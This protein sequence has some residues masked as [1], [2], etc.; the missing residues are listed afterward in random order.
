MMA[1]SRQAA[2]ETGAAGS[3]SRED[4]GMSWS[5]Q[6]WSPEQP[7]LVA[8][9]TGNGRADIVGFGLDGVWSSLNNGNG[10]FQPP[11][12]VLSA[13]SFHTG[14]MVERHLRMLADLSGD[15]RADIAGFGDA[16]VWTA[17]NNGDGTFQPVKFVVANLGYN[18]G[19]RVDQHP[20]FLADVT[21][22]GKA[23]I[24]GF[25]NDGVW[26]ALSNGDG[27][28]QAPKFVLNNMGYNQGWRVDQHPRFVADVT[29][30]G[31]ADIIGFGN[32]GV[33]VALSNGDGTFQ[34]AKLV[35]AG[36]NPNQG[37]QGARHPRMMGDLSGDRRA[38]IVG[39][40]DAGVYSALSNGN[41]S[42][43][44]ATF[45]L[46]EMGYNKGWRVENHPRFAADV[47]GD[48]K[49]D[50]VGFGNDGVWV[51]VTGG[52]GA[53]LVLAGF[54]YNQ[55]WRVASHPRYL[56]DLTG[57]RKA[58][59]IG[60]GNDGVWIALSNG[61]GSFQPASFVLA[62]FGYHAGPVVQKI[63]IDFQTHNDDL[64]SNSLLHIF[65]KNRSS[66]SSDSGG[67]GTYAA[68][69]QAYLEH[70]ADW[71]GKN[72]YLGYA[73]NA[74][75]GQALG[76]N[77]TKQINIQLRSKPIPLEE[78]L[79]PAVNIHILAKSTD[80]WKFDYTLTITL[81]DGTQLPPFSSNIN[82]LT[83]IVLNQDNRDYSGI[84]AE[85]RPIPP[86]IKPGTNSSLTGVAIEFNTHGDD[87]NSD[88]TLNIHIVNRLSAT[89]SQDISVATDV[90]KGQTFPDSGDTYK[91]IDLPFAANSIL[92]RDMV[93]PVV[94]INIAAGEDQWIFDYRVTFFFGPSQPYSWT[95]SGV[96]LDQEHHKHMG[97]Y[98]GRPFPTLFYPQAPITPN[99]FQRNKSISLPFVRQK[100]QELFNSRQFLGSL[101]PF[102]KFKI[103]STKTF[104]DQI[105][106]TFTDLQSIQNDPP[107]P[108]GQP[109]DPN[110]RMG[111]RYSHSIS[112]LGPL[113][114]WFGIG[115]HLND[116]NSQSITLSVNEGDNQTPLTVD[117]QFETDGPTEITGS[118]TIDVIKFQITLH[119]TLRFHEA[120]HAVDLMGWVDD[121]TTVTFTPQ[122]PTVSNLPP[123]Y[124][125]AGT[126]LGKT[127]NDRT[128]DPARYRTDLIGQ[129]VHVVFTTSSAFDPGGIIQKTMREGIFNKFSDKDSITK[130]TLRDSIN[131]LA[132]S[133]LMGGVIASGNP[134]LVPYPGP[135]HLTAVTPPNNGVVTLSYLSPQNSFVYQKPADW[136]TSLAPGA[137]A[138]IDHIVVLMQEN[139]SFDHML[140]YLS[141]P[142]EK[143]GMNRNDVD[144]LKGG[145]FNMFNGRKCGSFRLAAGDTIFSPGPPNGAERVAAAIN[146]GKMDGFVQAQA[147]E[148]GPATAHRVMGHHTA[149]NVP[150]Y[151]SLARDFAI[152]QRWFASH[153]GPTFPNRFYSLTGRPNVDAWGAWEYA[154]SS[155][156]RP[157]LTDTIF[158]HLS[159]RGVSWKCFEH[160]YSFLRFFERHTFDGDNI[161]SFTDPLK[162]FAALARSGNLPS[163]SFIEPHYVDYPPDSFCDEPPSDIRN[164]QKFMR[165]LVETLVASPKWDKTLLIITYDEH[166]GFYDHVPPPVAVPVA[167]GMLTTTGLRVPFFAVSP[168]VKSG[169]VF[170]TDTLH[171]DHTSILKT[172][173]RRFMSNNPPYMGARYAAAHDLSEILE[174]QIRPGPF[175]PFIPYTLVYAAS[176]MCLDLPGGSLSAGASLWQF[177]PNGTD[178]Q[179][180][181]LEDAGNGFFYIRTFAGLYVT[182]NS[183]A[184]AA[185]GIKQDRKYAPGSTG[186]LN[187]DLQK[188]KFSFSGFT[189]IE[190]AN[191]TITCAGVPG[192]VLQP[193]NGSTGSGV[194]VVLGDPAPTH[195]PL[196]TANPWTVTSSFLP[197][198]KL[199]HA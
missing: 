191:Y 59:I 86:R 150:T 147:D 177:S 156:L 173:T 24:I 72:P 45:I 13:F 61:D 62:D 109:L 29:G 131:A 117:L 97:V 196:V 93:L 37:W 34:Q 187:P 73:I 46:A 81:D 22:D 164:S 198:P 119:F 5:G 28:F 111:I 140:G 158:D 143:G 160:F 11:N 106:P 90:A 31:K 64:N 141:L 170:G 116:I 7:R 138:N 66:D 113:T 60:F 67:P 169:S 36:F 21:G 181:R 99:Q 78:L 182:A 52:S 104:G 40:G 6:S 193:V 132:S 74:G 12:M 133:W 134:E 20:R 197:P 179:K 124:K 2:T 102:L 42:F 137:L 129:V 172:I 175:R 184:G 162:G 127:L 95:V 149:D 94:F 171:F 195:S 168:W 121:M 33:W 9:L 55:G 85:F 77:S 122:S 100:L 16:G 65:V 145:E 15:G 88:T 1:T 130:V 167:P 128:L 27:T 80:T 165:S 148:C 84:C 57:D 71:F 19:W 178:A 108:D 82:G 41:G 152:C 91:R 110:F 49:A 166:G 63:T 126:F 79:L 39:F 43:A 54:C 103:D 135:C 101:D 194:A 188:W 4:K 163:V 69:L 142:F 25:G 125:V 161:G 186:P 120:T 185:P 159:E 68:N 18:Q 153:P 199:T 51:S 75:Q 89:S 176:K 96:V 115:V 8:D 180:F 146:G 98:N 183:T 58:D 151:D 192:K 136:P 3:D 112:D 144:G 56:A 76:D 48:G 123:V 114:T 50:I 30:D 70:D 10:S 107:P 118:T 14:W 189:A 17:L 92:L 53:K 174:S 87:R 155:P 190:P 157:V 38:D 23:D 44:T 32:D 154:N 105:P 83:G 35:L 26:V 139:R 47:T